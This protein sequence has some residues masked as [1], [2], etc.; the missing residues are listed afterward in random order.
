[1]GD[2][3]T[4]WWTGS[5]SRRTYLYH[6]T[7]WE[8]LLGVPGGEP[9]LLETGLL[10]PQAQMSPD[11]EEALRVTQLRVHFFVAWHLRM[12]ATRKYP[13]PVGYKADFVPVL[14]V[15]VNK[16]LGHED[17][18]VFLLSDVIT[19]ECPGGKR[20]VKLVIAARVPD[21]NAATEWQCP[22]TQLLKQT[23]PRQSDGIIITKHVGDV[24]PNFSGAVAYS[25]VNDRSCPDVVFRLIFDQGGW[26]M[27]VPHCGD[28]AGNFCDVQVALAK[29]TDFPDLNLSIFE[30]GGGIFP[31]QSLRIP[32]LVWTSTGTRHPTQERYKVAILPPRLRP[33]RA[34]T[35]TAAQDSRRYGG[36]NSPHRVD[37]QREGF[38]ITARGHYPLGPAVLVRS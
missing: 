7:K 29:R 8:N 5:S 1:M 6:G 38:Y 21:T 22:A 9:G 27:M 18:S 33:A 13:Y 12:K 35:I 15:S 23:S 20:L 34:M 30:R 4:T 17:Y 31:P 3:R 26:T 2:T 37:K 19:Y 14:K 10:R 24:G 16:L 32:C 11:Y 36:T 28:P 25:A